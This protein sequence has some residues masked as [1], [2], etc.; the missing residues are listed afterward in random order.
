L[1]SNNSGPSSTQQHKQRPSRTNTTQRVELPQ[2]RNTRSSTIIVQQQHY[3]SSHGVVRSHSSRA[4]A[5]SEATAAATTLAEATKHRTTAAK[6][7][8]HRPKQPAEEATS[9]AATTLTAKQ[10]QTKASYSQKRRHDA[11]NNAYN[12][13]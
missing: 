13:K 6:K 12:D 11:C 8:Q 4:T 1:P 7:P 2:R 5:S 3:S 9:K 10:P